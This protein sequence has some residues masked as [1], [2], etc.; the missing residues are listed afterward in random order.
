MRCR[1][2]NATP[3]TPCDIW[4]TSRRVLRRASAPARASQ[5][6]RNRSC[7]KRTKASS[8]GTLRVRRTLRPFTP[9]SEARERE[10]Q[11]EQ[12]KGTQRPGLNDGRR[13]GTNAHAKACALPRARPSVRPPKGGSDLLEGTRVLDCREVTWVTAL[14][15]RLNCAA[16]DLAGTSL[17]QEGHKIDG[18]GPRDG[19]ETRVHGS[20]D[21]LLE[22]ALPFNRIEQRRVFRHGKGQRHLTLERIRNADHCTLGDVCVHVDRLFY[23]P[24]TETMA[25]DVD[26]VVRASED[27]EVAVRVA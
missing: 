25:G 21:L 5:R 20:Q 9:R 23:L 10:R 6:S 15:Q 18:L 2:P 14:R 13:A 8:A 1:G 26:H 24:R 16:E 17:W 7:S 4:K 22:H 27:E 19:A 3:P 12:G 11:R